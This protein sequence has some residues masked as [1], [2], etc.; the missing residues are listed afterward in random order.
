[1]IAETCHVRPS[2][3]LDP[4]DELS[5]IDKIKLDI[6]VLTARS[7]EATKTLPP[8]EAVE[9]LKRLKKK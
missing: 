3:I 1:M 6:S 7:K 9:L 4:L 2:D 5:Y 8:H